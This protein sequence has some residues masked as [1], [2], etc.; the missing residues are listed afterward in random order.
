[1]PY[2]ITWFLGPPKVKIIP[3]GFCNYTL[4]EKGALAFNFAKR[5]HIFTGRLG[6][7]FL[8]HAAVWPQQIWAKN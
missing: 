4:T 7:K 2:V 3:T 5:L 1:M 8:T 6:S